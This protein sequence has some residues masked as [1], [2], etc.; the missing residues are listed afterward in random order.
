MLVADDSV[1]HSSLQRKVRLGLMVDLSKMKKEQR[2]ACSVEPEK[3][4]GFS[5]VR[6][7]RRASLWD[8]TMVCVVR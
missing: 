8:A 5:N 4:P 1:P 3:L 7:T 6:E 2:A